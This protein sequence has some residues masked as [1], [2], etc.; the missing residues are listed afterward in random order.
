MTYGPTPIQS[1]ARGVVTNGE[2]NRT[3]AHLNLSVTMASLVAEEVE[4][5]ARFIRT[6]PAPRIRIQGTP[7][8]WPR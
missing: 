4:R 8:G 3:T 7:E 2:G 1:E 6:P 5:K